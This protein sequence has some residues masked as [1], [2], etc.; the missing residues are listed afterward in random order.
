MKNLFLSLLL[1]L[2]S[3]CY[4]QSWTLA[5]INDPDGYSLIRS[6]KGKEFLVIDTVK[7]DWFFYCIG[8]T[9]SQWMSVI[10]P[11]T[12]KE[13][14]IH[15][16]CI[17][18]FNSLAKE[19]QQ[20]LLLAAFDTMIAAEKSFEDALRGHTSDYSSARKTAETISEGRYLPALNA[21]EESFALHPDSVFFC[22]FVRTLPWVSGSADETIPSVFAS[23][24]LSQTAFVDRI[25][26]HWENEHE[27]E[28]FIANVEAGIGL[29]G[30]QKFSEKQ[31]NAELK[32]LKAPCAN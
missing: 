11:A 13:G 24:W 14:F 5:V 4:C 27:R 26:C 18:L 16:S 15:K 29:N 6:G 19:E 30:Q 9:S 2:S 21:L 3:P 28:A 17:R 8:D 23:C 20:R 12:G 31:L 22:A 10:N 32:K 25:I 1:A 7:A